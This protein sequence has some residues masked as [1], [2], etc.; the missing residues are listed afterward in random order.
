M[1]A[2][3]SSD[4]TGYFRCKFHRPRISNPK[5]FNIVFSCIGVLTHNFLKYHSKGWFKAGSFLVTF[6]VSRTHKLVFR[7]T[8]HCVQLFRTWKI[9]CIFWSLIK[10][11]LWRSV[12]MHLPGKM[13]GGVTGADTIFIRA[14]S[15]ISGK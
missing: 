7:D 15:F 3:Y 5:D 10:F 2:T 1:S 12:V 6:Y 4:T 14:W 13:S 9:W 8:H 11:R